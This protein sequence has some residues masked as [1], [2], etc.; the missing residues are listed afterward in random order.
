MFINNEAN[1]T[2]VFRRNRGAV[3]ITGKQDMRGGVSL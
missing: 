3:E 1:L 2:A